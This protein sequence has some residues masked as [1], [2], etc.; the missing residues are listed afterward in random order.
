MYNYRHP[1]RICIQ[2]V[3]T[4]WLLLHAYM[5]AQWGEW[6]FEKNNRDGFVLCVRSFPLFYSVSRRLPYC[7][8][9]ISSV[10]KATEAAR[11]LEDKAASEAEGE[12]SGKRKRQSND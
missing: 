10:V 7:W 6:G 4:Q 8:S 1:L 11:S 9:R 12:A 5:A 3:H 2:Y